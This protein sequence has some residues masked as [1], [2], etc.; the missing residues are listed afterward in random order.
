[1]L[2]RVCVSGAV[3]I[4]ATEADRSRCQRRNWLISRK[5]AGES[6]VTFQLNGQAAPSILDNRFA[7]YAHGAA[8]CLPGA[9]AQNN[10]PVAVVRRRERN[11]LGHFNRV[12]LLNAPRTPD[13]QA[14]ELKTRV[15]R[16]EHSRLREW[17]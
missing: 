17:V 15:N 2:Y 7:K 6:R 9:Q 4:R 16:S 14:V 3:T 10:A 1:M 8:A 11:E 12:T 13:L 5:V